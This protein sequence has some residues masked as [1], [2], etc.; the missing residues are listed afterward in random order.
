MSTTT[1]KVWDLWVRLTHWTVA[2]GVFINLFELTEE[3]GTW[4]EYVGYAVAGIVVSRLIW[5][6]IGT[7]Y[8]R[9][10]DFFP[11]PNRIKNHL[12]SIGGK[13]EKHLGHNPFGALMMF[14]LW[15]VIIGLGVTG[16]MMGMDAYWGEE[17]L[18]EGHELLANSLYVLIPLH[19]LSA[20]GMG[21]IQK[22]NLVK[23]MITG[24]KT[25]RRDY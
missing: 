15:G 20:I 24:N 11:T 12:Q 5:G 10:S 22:Q 9:F 21:F 7:K 14:A 17:W 16:Y 18:Q 1:V 3:G 19:V 2:I 25:V 6:F 13:G 4:H 8:A 23:A